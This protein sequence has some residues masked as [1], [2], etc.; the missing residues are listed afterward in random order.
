VLAATACRGHLDSSPADPE[1]RSLHARLTEWV[2]S[3]GIEDELEPREETLLRASLGELTRQQRLDA[4][5]AVEGLAVLAWALGQWTFPKHDEKVDPYEVTDAVGFLADHTA[6]LATTASLRSRDELEACRE[7]LYAIHCRLREIGRRVRRIDFD[8][9]IEP[10]GL[11]LLN[12]DESRLV[13]EGDLGILG[14][15]LHRI[16]KHALR[17][18][19]SIIRERHRAAIWLL[20]EHPAYYGFSIDT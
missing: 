17:S 15:P 18:C 12:I 19:E 1:A 16:D 13:I 8:K 2:S 20:G 10:K 6:E 9:W 14:Q 3:V 4:T 7:L 5:W 11:V